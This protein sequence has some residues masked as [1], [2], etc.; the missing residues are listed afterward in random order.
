M[1]KGAGT[2]ARKPLMSLRQ[3]SEQERMPLNARVVVVEI[4]KHG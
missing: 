1:I 2:E 3:Y 4:E